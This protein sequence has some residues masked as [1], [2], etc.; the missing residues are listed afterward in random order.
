MNLIGG[1]TDIW[2]L[3]R[4]SWIPNYCHR[5]GHRFLNYCVDIGGG[6]DSADG[7]SDILLQ[8]DPKSLGINRIAAIPL[9]DDFLFYRR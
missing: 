7:V 9:C 3:I 5:W 6:G 4:G 1:W 8:W 2:L